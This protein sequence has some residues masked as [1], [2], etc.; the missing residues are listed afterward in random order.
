MG[1]DPVPDAAESDPVAP[2]HPVLPNL[3]ATAV[4][5]QGMWRAWTRVFDKPES[6]CLDLLDNC[7]DATLHNS[8]NDI[9]FYGR[10]VMAP[11]EG[12]ETGITITNNSFHEIK[13]LQEALTVYKSSKN[14]SDASF[15]QFDSVRK[16]AIGENG[17][18]L[19]HGCATL[20]NCSFV[21]SRNQHM[22]EVGV[23]AKDLQSPSGVCLPTFSFEVSHPRDLLDICHSLKTEADEPMAAA[24]S[25]VAAKELGHGDAD[26]GIA[27]L[28]TEIQSMFRGTFENDNH[29]FHLILCNLHHS[30]KVVI[31][32]DA[33]GPPMNASRIFLDEIKTM[34]PEYYINIP[35]EGFDFIIDGVKTQF[36]YWQ[37]RLVELT[38]F[39]INIPKNMPIEDMPDLGNWCDIGYNLRIYCG[40]DAQRLKK[41]KEGSGTSCKLYIYS[42]QAGRLIEKRTDARNMLHLHAS[43]SDFMQ[44]LT[45]IIADI[46]AELPL[47]PTKD[48]IAW[49]EQRD[50][51]VH[52]S[53]LISWAGGIVSLYWNYHF[54]QIKDHGSTKTPKDLL[55]RIVKSF[56][57][58][59]SQPDLE[60]N[61]IVPN[62]VH[63]DF[64][65]FAGIKWRKRVAKHTGRLVIHK[66]PG[67]HGFHVRKGCDTAFEISSDCVNQIVAE[68][69]E[70]KR[71]KQEAQS[72][73][74]KRP[75][76]KKAT[77]LRN[78]DYVST[79]TDEF[80]EATKENEAGENK[81]P[82]R[83]KA[84]AA[85]H[86][87]SLPG[88]DHP[89]PRVARMPSESDATDTLI[90]EKRKARSH[91]TNYV[92][93]LS[94][95]SE[96]EADED[97]I[98]IVTPAKGPARK[99][100]TPKHG[101]DDDGD[102]DDMKQ[103][104]LEKDIQ[105]KEEQLKTLKAEREARDSHKVVRQLLSQLDGF[106]KKKKPIGSWQSGDASD[107]QEQLRL[108]TEERDRY[109]S[110][111]EELEVLAGGGLRKKRKR[112]ERV[113]I[114]TDSSTDDSLDRIETI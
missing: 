94:S 28:A 36:T 54:K 56:A 20:S 17:V 5:G 39:R 47:M 23:I 81:R 12:T 74:K 97:V 8:N 65:S 106:K 69:N 21:L 113:E 85:E 67:R 107:L 25:A 34:L 49:S 43:G 68:S 15:Q 86:V 31:D 71:M 45:V 96:E 70:E 18:G 78:S 104:L 82:A 52:K 35:S 38:E 102:D 95:D 77:P 66:S 3:E 91:A 50:G 111:M 16:D 63:G 114:S 11:L 58:K 98:G 40:F 37:K 32:I 55:A 7:L 112:A 24:I 108:V 1:S 42:R 27:K 84:R 19:K 33:E 72:A 73:G 80:N 46:E 48:G 64:S 60:D 22:V 90:G 93:L 57:N 51:E 76:R 101:D 88:V 109:K 53:N 61:K 59:N 41:E 30:K 26:D 29:V 14:S 92:D 75:A 83:R 4:D 110:R 62:L 89:T 99:K 2:I 100:R 6:A 79:S 10:V 105:L 87:P 9:S 103:K 44:G 13:H